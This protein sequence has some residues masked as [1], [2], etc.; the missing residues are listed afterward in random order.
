MVRPWYKN[1]HSWSKITR[2]MVHQFDTL[3]TRR[4]LS[5]QQKFRFQISENPLAQWNGTFRLHRPDPSHHMLL[6]GYCSCKQDAKEQYWATSV[7][8][9]ANSVFKWKG[10]F[11][12]DRQKSSDRSKWTVF[13]GCPKY[14]GRTERMVRSIWF[15][16]EI[17][18]IWGWMESARY[19]S[20]LFSIRN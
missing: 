3:E 2:I 11:W 16:T 13:K 20:F 10:T 8:Y 5:I 6:F 17:S 19:F 18:G 9:W 12:S 14:S 7:Q 15:L 4:A 1:G